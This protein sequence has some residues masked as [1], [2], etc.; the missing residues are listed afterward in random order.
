MVYT[1][2]YYTTRS[3]SS[4][5]VVSSY[6]VS[7][8]R[9]PICQRHEIPW[10]KVPFVPRPAL[11][12]DPITAFGRRDNSKY[13]DRYSRAN[14]NSILDPANRALI[15]PSAKVLAQPIKPYVSAREKTRERVFKLVDEHTKQIEAGGNTAASAFR[16]SI[17]FV[18]PRLHRKIGDEFSR[19]RAKYAY[20]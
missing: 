19:E 4:R 15:K 11:V 17:D 9:R 1:S 18:L 8:S 10:D 7:T 13:S 16:D 6:T 14:N 2:D 20:A 3:Y 5:P 12:A